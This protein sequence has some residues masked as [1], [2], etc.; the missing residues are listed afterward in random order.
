MEEASTLQSDTAHDVLAA[1]GIDGN[2]LLRVHWLCEMPD[3]QRRDGTA[4]RCPMPSCDPLTESILRPHFIV[5]PQATESPQSP[6]PP[7]PPPSSRTVVNTHALAEALSDML[8]R[9]LSD[10]DKNNDKDKDDD[11]HSE[12]SS[13]KAPAPAHKLNADARRRLQQLDAR[14]WADVL[15]HMRLGAVPQP[16][17][18]D[19]WLDRLRA[20]IGYCAGTDGRGGHMRGSTGNYSGGGLGRGS[21]EGGVALA[22]HVMFDV[23]PQL[24]RALSC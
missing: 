16:A 1:R 3:A 19:A 4:L 23:L 20:L 18:W 8:D 5:T 6:P 15:V 9:V 24:L 10:S 2:P 13:S 22:D 17:E 11:R 21:S 12:T 14:A 7:P